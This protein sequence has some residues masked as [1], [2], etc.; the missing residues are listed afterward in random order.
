MVAPRATGRTP[1]RISPRSRW[2]SAVPE[3]QAL[4]AGLMNL[5]LNKLPDRQ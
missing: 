1:S 3:Q 4:R 2:M 5:L